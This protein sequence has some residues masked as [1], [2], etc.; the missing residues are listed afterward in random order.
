MAGL[1]TWVTANWPDKLKFGKGNFADR[2]ATSVVPM[3]YFSQDTQDVFVWFLNAD[4]TGG[5]WVDVGGSAAFADGTG[6][7]D[8]NG[9]DILN[10]GVV[11]NATTYAKITNS[12]NTGGV[13]LEV[14][15]GG[16]NETL[17][18]KP[19]GTG[20]LY[21]PGASNYEDRVQSANH[22]PN[23]QYVDNKLN[24]ASLGINAGAASMLTI[25][26]LG[27]ITKTKSVHTIYGSAYSDELKTIYGGTNGDILIIRPY[28]DSYEIR[29][30]SGGNIVPDS[31]TVIKL[32]N[33]SMFLILYF[34]GS[35]WRVIG[36][37]KERGDMTRN[38]LVHAYYTGT[39]T[40]FQDRYI[41]LRNDG[42]SMQLTTVNG[43][44]RIGWHSDK[45]SYNDNWTEDTAYQPVSAGTWVTIATV[46][47]NHD[48]DDFA[49][50]Y[51][52]ITPDDGGRGYELIIIRRLIMIRVALANDTATESVPTLVTVGD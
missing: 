9:N 44:R 6:L 14:A 48:Y 3:I 15:G 33:T 37:N 11:A 51:I 27:A 10:F 20:A 25:N 19:K 8:V 38:Y 7:N 17:Y 18:L 29:V 35:Y 31:G 2:P 47:I 39:N 50:V 24:A 1:E 30:S 43:T 40:F 21:I 41:R 28:H 22:I 32:Y 52:A 46:V 4:G 36:H 16:E 13:T 12:T 49:R 26:Y 45:T 42:K 23:R 5:T 34:D